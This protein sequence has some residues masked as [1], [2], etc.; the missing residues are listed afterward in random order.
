MRKKRRRRPAWL[1]RSELRTFLIGGSF[2]IPL[3]LALILS[4][5]ADL[6]PA[7]GPLPV[8]LCAI[9]IVLCASSPFGDAARRIRFAFGSYLAITFCIPLGLYLYWPRGSFV[10]G[11]LGGQA[12]GAVFWSAC[13]MLL[14]KKLDPYAQNLRN[15]SDEE[16][17]KALVYVAL[18]ILLWNALIALFGD[19]PCT[20]SKCLR[21]EA[22]FGT[23]KDLFSSYW[24]CCTLCTAAVAAYPRLAIEFVRRVR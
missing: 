22:I 3:P 24:A 16:V 18:F 8:A 13:L 6:P 12:L 19:R 17:H 23:Q 7:I 15:S 14:L 5:L 2:F 20:S 11:L 4:K 21:G 9:G 1:N 10:A